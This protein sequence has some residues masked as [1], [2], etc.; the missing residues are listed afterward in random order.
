[1]QNQY[2]IHSVRGREILD[3]RGNPTIEAEVTLEGG[4]VGR[5][6]V[7]SGASTGAFEAV[8]LRDRE[9]P[10]YRG[11]GVKQGKIWSKCNFR[12]FFG[13]CKNGCQCPS[14]STVS[15][16][17]RCECKETPCPDDEYY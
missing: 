17:W 8:E 3:S 13:C 2:R 11:T 15:V 4:C 14:S 9:L 1:M 5:A 12:C 6:S 16:Y 10:R 7:P